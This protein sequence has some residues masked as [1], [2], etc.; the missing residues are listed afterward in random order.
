MK[1]KERVYR[2]ILS[3]VLDEGEI[4][5]LFRQRELARVCGLAVSSV[6]Y[7][8]KP[9]ENLGAIR[10]FRFGF[11]VIDAK[12]ILYYWASIRNLRGD[13]IY[14]TF[15]NADVSEIES[16]VPANTIFTAYTAFKFKFK[17]VPA[18]YGEVLVYGDREDFIRR[19]GS[20][21]RGIN[22][23]LIVLKADS[24]L[25]KFK[26]APTAQIFVDLWNLREWYAKDFIRELEAIIN[27]IL[28]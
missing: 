13:I 28:E 20:Q 6:N 26:I 19:F 23:N 11:R 22:P 24:H 27:G 9:L 1:G 15:L 18:D 25:N 3:V 7:A 16:L 8:L 17:R 4:G 5:R 10:K 2:E 21:K 12:K 14:Q